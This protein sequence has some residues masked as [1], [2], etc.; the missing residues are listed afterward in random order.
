MEEYKK[1]YMLLFNAM[2]DALEQMKAQNFGE[3]RETL[4]AAQRA[5]EDIYIHAED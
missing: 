1:M 2:T 3:A 4:I 5:A